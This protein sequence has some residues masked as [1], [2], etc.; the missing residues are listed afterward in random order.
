MHTEPGCGTCSPDHLGWLLQVAELIVGL[1]HKVRG[2]LPDTSPWGK[3][4]QK[5]VAHEDRTM[6]TIEEVVRNVRHGDIV[7]N[8][9]WG[10]ALL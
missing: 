4:V 3:W 1:A 9:G 2:T 5:G 6:P 8:Y 7:M 10:E